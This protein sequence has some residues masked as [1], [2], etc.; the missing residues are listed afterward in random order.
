[1]CYITLGSVTNFGL[2]QDSH[3]GNDA[4]VPSVD[5]CSS[6]PSSIQSV[7][8]SDSLKDKPE[9]QSPLSVLE[10]FFTEDVVSPASTISEHGKFSYLVLIN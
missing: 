9:Q 2:F 8:D 5:V 6:S 10:Q 7:E 4:S 1:M 3:L